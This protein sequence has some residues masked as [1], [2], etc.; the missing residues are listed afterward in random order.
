MSGQRTLAQTKALANCAQDW[1]RWHPTF[2]LGEKV[3]VA[4]G[5]YA[6]CPRCQSRPPSDARLIL[7]ALHR[8][9]EQRREDT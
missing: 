5:L 3:C 8:D 9:K 1:H 7:C 6:Y 2:T 4:C